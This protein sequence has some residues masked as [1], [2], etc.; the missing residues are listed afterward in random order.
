MDDITAVCRHMWS[1][2]NSAA[3]IQCASNQM[4]NKRLFMIVH[5]SLGSCHLLLFL[6]LIG[7]VLLCFCLVWF[8]WEQWKSDNSEVIPKCPSVH[9]S[10]VTMTLIIHCNNRNQSH[11]LIV[12]CSAC[13]SILASYIYWLNLIF[14]GFSKFGAMKENH[15]FSVWSLWEICSFKGLVLPFPLAAVVWKPGL[16][17]T[18]LNYVEMF[19]I[20]Y[21]SIYLPFPASLTC[22]LRSC[23]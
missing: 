12:K 4:V 3:E 9:T 14:E 11:L 18:S 22:Q 23:R 19:L 16:L 5:L 6:W 10:I 13:F 17:I 21:S 20:Y 1:L 2:R 8:T 15:F 7:F